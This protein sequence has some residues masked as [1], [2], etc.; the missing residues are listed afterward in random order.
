MMN[1]LPLLLASALAGGL[2]MPGVQRLS[3]Q[4]TPAAGPASRP[5]AA[6]LPATRPAAPATRPTTS[7]RP[8]PEPLLSTADIRALFDQGK[9]ADVLRQIARVIDLRGKA[10]EGYDRYELLMLRMET[11]LRMK[12]QDAALRTATEAAASTD[13]PQRQAVAKAMALL[14]RRSRG[15]LYTPGIP[16][17]LK[18]PPID[19]VEPDSRKK[20]LAALLTDELELAT[21]KVNA[22]MN[23]RSLPA[24]ADALQQL[25]GLDELERGVGGGEEAHRM[26]VDLRTRGL[27]VMA[28]TVQVMNARTEEITR[29]ANELVRVPVD[30]LVNGQLITTTQLRKR[31]L[32]NNDRRDLTEIVRT[33]DMIIPNVRGLM[34]ATGGKVR[35]VEDLII[36]AEELRRRA[37]RAL[38]ADY[39]NI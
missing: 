23:G 14:I 39:N 36:A 25:R 20:A 26:V 38:N 21:P 13:D 9:Y 28:Q 3:A 17:K 34:E 18:L 35:E 7:A 32:V 16:K 6:P 5:A 4:S 37:D 22:A 11:L 29:S 27:T 30:T 2:L 15:L 1:R 33:A 10:G 12:S 8:G 24:I 31:G 19:I